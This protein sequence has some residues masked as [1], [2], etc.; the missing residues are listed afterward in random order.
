LIAYRC[1]IEIFVTGGIG[2]VHR[3]GESSFDISA[4]LSELGRTP[5]TIISAGIK[6]ILDIKKTLEVL[7]TKGVCVVVFNGEEDINGN[8]Q[9]PSFFTR[10]SG[11][12]IS[13]NIKTIEDAALMI[14]QHK[15]LGL[16]S[17]ILIAV[18]IPEKDKALGDIVNNAISDAL[19]EVK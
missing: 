3:G 15:K 6:S 14:A 11:C 7:E 18:P 19:K 1:G 5:I 9:F 8:V 4:D 17:G 13:Y 2:G 12:K 10:D 16:D